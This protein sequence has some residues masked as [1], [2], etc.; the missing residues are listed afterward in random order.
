M[1]HRSSRWSSFRIPACLAAALMGTASA[2]VGGDCAVAGAPAAAPAS[3]LAAASA[4]NGKECAM[5]SI[6]GADAL[7]LALDRSP[8]R[9]ARVLLRLK[10]GPAPLAHVRQALTAAGAEAESIG[11]RP[12]LVAELTAQQLR[13]VLATCQVLSVQRDEP[14]P[15]N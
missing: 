7:L 1:E 11:D 3:A 12:L 15:A 10:P 5:A 4:T 9:P 14:A 8:G 13:A 2:L 6:E